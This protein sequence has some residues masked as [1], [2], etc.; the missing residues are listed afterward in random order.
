MGE[1]ACRKLKGRGQ[2]SEELSV[3]CLAQRS[4]S[5]SIRQ[6]SRASAAGHLQQGTHQDSCSRGKEELER[7]GGGRLQAAGRREHAGGTQVSQLGIAGDDA[8]QCHHEDL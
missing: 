5:S 8:L 6:R 1:M 4:S 7:L 3:M 2:E